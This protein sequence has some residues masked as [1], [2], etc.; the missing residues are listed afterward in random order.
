MSSQV[1]RSGVGAALRGVL[2]F[3]V[4]ALA[5]CS[6]DERK[7]P[8][9]S[10]DTRPDASA[11]C[12][13]ATCRE[14]LP[15]EPGCLPAGCP[16][17]DACRTFDGPPTAP[18]EGGCLTIENCPFTWKPAA[19]EGDAC[20][21]GAGGC[22][23]RSGAACSASGACETGNCV[24]TAAGPSV[25][26]AQACAA[27]E[28]CTPD[29]SG[30]VPAEPCSAEGRRCSGALHQSCVDGVWQTVTDCGALGCSA[31]LDGCLR[32]AGQACE[33]D[34]SCG[35]GSCLATADGNRVCCTGACNAGCQ[36]CAPE[37]TACVDVED[38]EVC[39]E[40]A[41]PTDPCRIYEPATVVTNRCSAGQCATP[42][43]ACTLFQPQRVDLECSATA[44]CDDAGGCGRPK[45]ELLAECT[46]SEQCVTAACVANAGGASVCC[47][48]ACAANEV[49]SP[50]GA[51]VLAPVCEVG[52]SQCSG[53]N[54]QRCVGGQWVTELACGVLGCSLAREGCLASAGQPCSSSLDCGEGTCQ[55]T[56]SGGS[57]CC[58]AACSG[59][60]RV[61]SALG[62]ACTNLQDD[63]D[64]GTIT[65]PA[66]STCRD[67]PPS[68]SALRCVAGQCGSA[69]QLCQGTP[70]NTGQSCSATNLCDGAGNCA[71]P[72]KSNGDPCTVGSE[73]ASNSCVDGVCCNSACN[74]LCETCETTGICRAAATDTA[75]GSV[76]CS[77]FDADCVTNTT[78][79]V[80]AC[81]GRGTCRSTADCGFRS[82]ATRCG[83]GG[84][85]DGQGTCE[86][87]SVSCAGETCS[88]ADV[89][90]SMQDFSTGL[91]TIGCG[92]GDVCDLPGAGPGPVVQLHCDQN[93]DCLNADEV[94]CLITN[95]VNSGETVCRQDCT[96]AAVGAELGA[97][98]E[99]L[100]VGQLC[101]SEVGNLFLQCPPG[102]TC[103]P[104][105]PTLSPDYRACR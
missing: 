60:C 104:V 35:E 20:S 31:E 3:V 43:Q 32:S 94:C 90:C 96:A 2:V 1:G 54:F 87:P 5:A 97:P 68:V 58:T 88:G 21:C 19:R 16:S 26:C 24:A 45:R 95:N 53:T 91:L 62:T 11:N 12:E 64:C 18:P 84:V 105:V 82:S 61:C 52:S 10:D 77:S 44:L 83:A 101:A 71:Q 22:V 89:C 79:T 49:C 76:S 17:D 41:C 46:S 57:V 39:G 63:A 93:A 55:E 33:S 67:F 27:T 47:S 38:D 73:C 48:Q 65:C 15:L 8:V 98:P 4:G 69:A 100:V 56:A 85:C 23:L 92:E 80:N 42:E 25:C 7:L 70:R 9:V 59:A 81:A 30:C 75:C 13:G 74:G 86:G 50:T 29:G 34:A 6:V 66:D 36:R 102:Q 40:I 51:C 99:M 72:K 37:G 103:S 14:E 28:V 78:N